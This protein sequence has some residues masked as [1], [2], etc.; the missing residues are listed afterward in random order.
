MTELLLNTI[1]LDP[2]RWTPEHMPYFKLDQLLSAIAGAGFKGLECWQYHLSGASLDEVAEYARRGRD[3]GLTFPVVGVYPQLHLEGP[4]K[5]KAWDDLQ[6]LIERAVVLEARV[7]KCF[8]GTQASAT[9]DEGSYARSLTFL[10]ALTEAAYIAGLILTGETHENTLFDSVTSCRRVLDELNA[11]NL[12]VCFQPYNFE[13]TALMCTDY[14]ALHPWVTHVHFQGRKNDTFVL[15]EEATLD[16][17]PLVK[18]LA[19]HHFAGYACIEFVKDCVVEKPEHF[20]I[21][22][23]LE[24]ATRDQAYLNQLFARFR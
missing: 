7:L 1:A 18:S 23:V 3:L 12:K 11:P 5:D 22:L 6:R 13:D 24:N 9:L 10:Q 20:P 19:D 21:P 16:Y 8:V 2:N 14:E 4:A 17:A 15:L